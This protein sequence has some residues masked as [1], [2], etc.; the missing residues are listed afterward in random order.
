MCGGRGDGH[1]SF[2][3]RGRGHVA[4]KKCTNYGMI[5]HIVETCWDLHGK[6]S[7][8]YQTSIQD[9][10]VSQNTTGN[11]SKEGTITLTK[12]DLC[13]VSSYSQRQRSGRII[14]QLSSLR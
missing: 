5:N 1:D 3:D 11:A 13:E 14:Y 9:G 10:K 7:W 8:A 12:E 4:F 2:S 6:T